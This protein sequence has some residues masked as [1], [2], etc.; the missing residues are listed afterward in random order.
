MRFNEVKKVFVLLGVVVMVSISSITPLRAQTASNDIAA[1]LNQIL[2]RVNTLP[3]SLVKLGAFIDAW[4]NPDTSTPTTTMQQ[5]FTQLGNL[6]TQD[7]NT[8]ASLQSSLN[9]SLLNNDGSNVYNSNQTGSTASISQNPA[10]TTNLQYANDLVYSSLLDTPFFPKDPRAGGSPGANKKIDSS[11]NY[12]LNASGLNIY[13]IRPAGFTGTPASQIRYQGFYNTIMAATSFNGYVLSNVYADK[14]QFTTLQQT[15]IQQATDPTKW[16]AQV[17]SE[18][19]GFVLRQLLLYQS[20]VFVLLTQMLQLQKQ[21]ITAQA[22]NT[23]VL[24]AVNQTNENM[25][26]SNAKGES[27]PST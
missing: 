8:Q 19:I 14:N 26:A 13:H 6:L 3:A 7:M 12:I 10:S 24:I 2:A 23:A 1:I 22:M 16:F 11:L 18:S 17:S 20:Q 15:L 21:M 25:M 27:S 4:M 9:A 5:S